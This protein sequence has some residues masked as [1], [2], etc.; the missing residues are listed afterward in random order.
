MMT[1]RRFQKWNVINVIYIQNDAC[2]V[3]KR[4][5]KWLY[6]KYLL[7]RQQ[8]VFHLFFTLTVS[9]RSWVLF[10]KL[11]GSINTKSMGNTVSGRTRQTFLG[12]I[13][14]VLEKGHFKRTQNRICM[15]NLMKVKAKGVSKD[16]SKWKEVICLPL[17]ETG[18]ISYYVLII[19]HISLVWCPGQNKRKSPL[20]FIHECRKRRLKD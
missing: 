16:R 4:G 18:V 13:G 8:M 3:P 5:N 9:I 2:S 12:Q 17:W 1:V 10:P 7:A 19:M 20:L 11:C 6:F 14:Q 15:R